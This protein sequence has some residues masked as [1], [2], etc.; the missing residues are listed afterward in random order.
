MLFTSV[1]RC[2]LISFSGLVVKSRLRVRVVSSV[3][4]GEAGV[5]ADNRYGTLLKV[6]VRRQSDVGNK[7]DVK[8]C[9]VNPACVCRNCKQDGTAFIYFLKITKENVN[10]M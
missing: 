2:R 10:V 7:L 8:T 6:D 4:K 5:N 3:S 9:S 1:V